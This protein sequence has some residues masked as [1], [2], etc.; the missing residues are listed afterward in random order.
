MIEDIPTGPQIPIVWLN[1]AGLA[2]DR[3]R[4]KLT[5]TGRTPV[6]AVG[7]SQKVQG[8]P[9]FEYW[10]GFRCDLFPRALVISDCGLIR[11][12]QSGI[13]GRSQSSGITGPTALR[14]QS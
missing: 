14:R 7:K 5:P 13:K 3:E 4:V 10:R 8:S 12:R 11:A 9:I 6:T 2:G 1:S